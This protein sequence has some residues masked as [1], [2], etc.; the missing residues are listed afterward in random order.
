M[1]LY[2]EM[3]R[4]LLAIASEQTSRIEEMAVNHRARQH[5]TSKY[6]IGRTIRVILDLLPV[7][8]LLSYS[9]RPLQIFGLIGGAM[10]LAGA[11]VTGW[12]GVGRL[13]GSISLN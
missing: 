8:F 11:L 3:H 6:G 9:T 13:S 5:G 4:F 12:L 1:K 2:G 10:G 7:K